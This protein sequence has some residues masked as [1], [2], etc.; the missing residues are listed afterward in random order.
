M[1]CHEAVK[2]C[3]CSPFNILSLNGI[4]YPATYSKPNKIT[5]GVCKVKRGLQLV[6]GA[7]KPFKHYY[8]GLGLFLVS[9][10]VSSNVCI[11]L[12]HL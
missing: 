12:E 9:V 2:S 10:P 3:T 6:T 8:H 5:L 1:N 11:D 4:H 7:V